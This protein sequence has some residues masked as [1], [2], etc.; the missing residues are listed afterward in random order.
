MKQ[1][2]KYGFSYSEL[3]DKAKEK[4]NEWYLNDP[5]RAYFLESDLNLD[6]R[7][8]YF[9]YSDLK[10]QF[11]LS[12]CQGDGVNIYGYLDIEKDILPNCKN[13]FTEKEIKRLSWYLDRY[14]YNRYKLKSND[15]Y[16]YCMADS[17]SFADD[18]IYDLQYDNIRNIDERIIHK[19]EIQIKSRV[20][21]VCNELEKRGYQYLYEIDES[22][23][24]E[25]CDGNEWY[26]DINGK[27]IHGYDYIL[28]QQA[29]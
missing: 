23:V 8:Y 24:K 11:S 15:H 14:G 20:K 16:A 2:V 22:E 9:P 5:D 26:F 6:L 1:F 25:S 12:Y 19:L 3:S 4:V 10:V 7:D 18:L 29:Q 27:Y 17:I 13:L 21:T 28:E